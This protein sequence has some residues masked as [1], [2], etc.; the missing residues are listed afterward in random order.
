VL[1]AAAAGA[2]AGVVALLDLLGTDPAAFGAGRTEAD[3]RTF[4]DRNDADLTSFGVTAAAQ[5]VEFPVGTRSA[6]P[7]KTS[8]VFTVAAATA[9]VRLD[10]G[11]CF[12]ASGDGLGAVLGGG[13]L[14]AAEVAR[15]AEPPGA[16]ATVLAGLEPLR[17]STILVQ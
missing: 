15:I 10:A 16:A 2:Q 17:V 5:G 1:D 11:L 6:R 9:R 7:A 12:P 14:G 13:C 4:A 3:A 8:E